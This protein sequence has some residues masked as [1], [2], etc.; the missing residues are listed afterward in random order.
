VLEEVPALTGVIEVSSVAYY[1]TIC[2]GRPR[3]SLI[4]IVKS[5]LSLCLKLGRQGERAELWRRKLRS[6]SFELLMIRWFAI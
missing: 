6:N 5:G 4:K 2:R 3:G 1:V